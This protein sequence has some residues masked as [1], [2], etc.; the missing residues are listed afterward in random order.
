MAD[1][2]QT[3][4]PSK[5]VFFGTVC[6]AMCRVI[7]RDLKPLSGPVSSDRTLQLSHLQLAYLPVWNFGAGDSR[8]SPIV[9]IGE[10]LL[11]SQASRGVEIGLSLS[12]CS[13]D[14]S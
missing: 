4:D 11:L 13:E 12:R 6:T 7:L 2:L 1:F 14:L 10:R 5:L 8:C 9:A 3:L